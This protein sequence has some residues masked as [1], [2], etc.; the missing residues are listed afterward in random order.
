MTSKAVLPCAQYVD[1][2]DDCTGVIVVLDAMKER[3][4]IIF[5]G[6]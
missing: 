5:S 1:S 2:R 4:N 6:L 3:W